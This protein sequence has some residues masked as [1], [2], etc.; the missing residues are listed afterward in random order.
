[1]YDFIFLLGAQGSGKTTTGR[2]LKEQLSSPYIELDWIR[3]FHLNHGWSDA[4]QKDHDMAVENLLFMLKNYKKH[5]YHNVIV[6]GFTE[7]DMQKFMQELKDE[8]FIVITLFLTNDDLLKQRVLTE[9]RDSGFRDYQESIR[10]NKRL[11]DDLTFPNEH[12]I[13]NTNRTPEE[14]LKQ[15]KELLLKE[16]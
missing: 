3:G 5:E 1:M 14:T 2:L 10:F 16:L 6:S 4:S 12:K 8:N 11:R 13:N 9:T 15:I 7:E